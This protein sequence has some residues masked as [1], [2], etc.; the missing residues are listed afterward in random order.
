MKIE[1]N[2][3]PAQAGLLLSLCDRLNALSPDD[4]AKDFSALKKLTKVLGPKLALAIEADI[5]R[6]GTAEGRP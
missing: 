2:L 6:A 1:L 4:L 5:T 3:Q